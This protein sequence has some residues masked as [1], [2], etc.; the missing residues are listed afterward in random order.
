MNIQEAHRQ[1]NLFL[2][3]VS[4]ES[5]PEFSHK[6]I[7]VFIHEAEVRLVKQ[8]YGGNNIYKTG[9]QETQ[10][11]TDD[12]NSLV[13]TGYLDSAK[14]FSSIDGQ[15]VVSPV[16]VD[17]VYSFSLDSIYESENFTSSKNDY[18]FFVKAMVKVNSS[19]VTN[20]V[21]TGITL[22]PQDKY[23]EVIKDPFNKSRIS[24]P[25]A[26]FED[27]CIKIDTNKNSFSPS[28]I[29]LTYI[30][31]PIPVVWTSDSNTYVS[32]EL[33]EQKQ[34]EAIQLAVTIALE[35]VESQRTNTQAGLINTIE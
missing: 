6:Q 8:A 20:P 4:S 29:R 15:L 9:Y 33:P 2:D 1:F 22:I 18:M 30:K 35:S 27:N 16:V 32:S 13:K 25:I 10:K 28:T 17:G 23:T 14:V 19:T 26:F 31:Y 7:D 5:T 24:S 3:K 12:L 21:Y 34:R 11:R